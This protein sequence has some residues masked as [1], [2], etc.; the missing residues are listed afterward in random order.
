MH[1]CLPNERI[2]HGVGREVEKDIANGRKGCV[3]DNPCR[4]VEDARMDVR[5]IGLGVNDER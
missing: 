5:E 1:I 4:D 3:Y 2:P